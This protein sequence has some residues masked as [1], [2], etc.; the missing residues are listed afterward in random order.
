MLAEVY[1][2]KKCEILKPIDSFSNN[3]TFSGNGAGL[4]T[5]VECLTWRNNK[6]RL[7]TTKQYQITLHV[8]SLWNITVTALFVKVVND[9]KSFISPKLVTYINI[10]NS[11]IV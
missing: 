10:D 6:D 3:F 4:L 7:L 11:E 2:M 9:P 1:T 8:L 5:V